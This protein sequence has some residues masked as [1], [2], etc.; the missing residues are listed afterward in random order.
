MLQCNRHVFADRLVSFSS[1]FVDG[2]EKSAHDPFRT[3]R[4][5][6]AVQC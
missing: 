3:G 5:V 4:F 2:L 6:G 1:V